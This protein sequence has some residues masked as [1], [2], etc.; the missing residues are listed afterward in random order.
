MSPISIPGKVTLV[1]DTIS[2]E[3]VYIQS[4]GIVPDGLVLFLDAAAPLSYPGFGTTWTDLSGNGNNGTLVNGVGY[5]SNNGVSLSFDGVNDYATT[6]NILVP[7]SASSY[8]VS[9]WCYRNRNNAVYEELLSQWTGAS[10]ANSFFFGFNNSNVR[11]TDNWS[12]VVVS[13][14]GNTGVWM[15][16][17]GVHTTSNAYI[18]LNGNLS[19]TRGSGFSYTGTGAFVIGRQGELNSEYFSGNI[20]QVSIYNKALTPQEVQQNFNALKGRFGL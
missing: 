19:A 7:T 13:G 16:L 4:S 14:A 20:S 8:T 1:K 12:S 5:N 3:A 15:N 11:F 9:V 6:G 10:S 2:A 18:F 17:V